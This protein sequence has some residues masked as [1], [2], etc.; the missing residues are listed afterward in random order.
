MSRIALITGS[1]D[2]IG[3][4]TALALAKTG[5]TLHL[6]GRNKERGNQTLSN[7]K[8]LNPEGAHRLFLVDLSSIHQ[9]RL[10]LNEYLESYKALDLLVLNALARTQKGFL[11]EEGL[12]VTFAVGPVSRYMFSIALNPLLLA[13]KD[14]RVVHIGDASRLSD[15]DYEAI[16]NSSLGVLKATMQSYS[17]SALMAYF[18]NEK[19]SVPHETVFP[20]V[21]R[22]K[23]LKEANWLP[24]F[25]R[26]WVGILEPEESGRRVC[27]HILNTRP[28]EVAGRFFKLEREKKLNSSIVNGQ[29]E[30]EALSRFCQ[31]KTLLDWNS[32]TVS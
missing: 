6:L 31:Q 30:F 27:Q 25:L 18:F 23:Q 10:F 19:T 12:D 8:A 7:V 22:T 26:R 17:A 32:A 21:V 3:K 11:T 28:Q 29:V 5:W 4:E 15:I 24:G 13:S 1:T 20:G 9:S 16:T 2:G 14:G